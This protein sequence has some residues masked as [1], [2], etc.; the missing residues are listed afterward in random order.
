[1]K[2]TKEK[3]IGEQCSNTGKKSEEEHQYDSASTRDRLNHCE[4]RGSYCCLRAFG[5]MSHRG[6]TDTESMDKILL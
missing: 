2:K 1:M 6:A 5:K 3:W 4:T